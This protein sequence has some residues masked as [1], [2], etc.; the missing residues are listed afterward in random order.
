[1]GSIVFINSGIQEGLSEMRQS[2]SEG[3]R[4]VKF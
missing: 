4:S 2:K 3:A 1:M